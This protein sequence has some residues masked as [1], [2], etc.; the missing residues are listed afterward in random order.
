MILT[1]TVEVMIMELA[2]ASVDRAMWKTGP[3][4]I[5]VEFLSGELQWFLG[6]MEVANRGSALTHSEGA[7]CFGAGRSWSRSVGYTLA[8]C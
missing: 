3:A 4:C 5:H 2:K 7:T 6:V 1:A 8:A